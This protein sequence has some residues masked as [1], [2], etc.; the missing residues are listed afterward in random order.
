[1]PV[2]G[3]DAAMD[4][5]LGMPL[6][7]PAAAFLSN[8]A[9]QRLVAG[10]ADPVLLAAVVGQP[11]RLAANPQQANQGPPGQV[12]R[13]VKP[14]D[15]AGALVG[16]FFE[17]AGA[18]PFGA[19]GEVLPP[20]LTVQAV[21]WDNATLDV[22]VSA[23]TRRGSEE[24][25][26]PK[27]LLRPAAPRSGLAPYSADVAAQA[28]TV[29]MGE[30]S[31]A[32]WEAKRPEYFG[33]KSTDAQHRSFEAEAHRRA[34]LLNVR[35][36]TLNTRLIQG[37][38]YNRFDPVIEREV[39]AANEA[40]GLKGES[41]LDPDLV[42]SMMFQESEMGTAGQHLDL[43]S[44]HPMKNRFNILQVI[45]S[46]GTALMTLLEKEHP[47][48]VE[49]YHLGQ[50]RQELN[51]AL[52]ERA[53]LQRRKQ[54][55]PQEAAR[56]AALDV[57]LKQNGEYFIYNYIAPGESAGFF[58]AAMELFN[59]SSPPLN[60][61]YDFWI[62]AAVFWLFEKHRAGMSWPDAVRAYNGSGAKANRYRDAVVGRKTAAE[63]A[64]SAGKSFVPGR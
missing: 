58:A 38:M 37:T 46:S 16:Q 53:A 40:H 45:D 22:L 21:E 61:T 11:V 49:K 35:R 14:D 15:V 44:T 27:R 2:R 24:I 52:E 12:I 31:I 51:E 39:A 36:A 63:S 18:V 30:A 26:V 19:S 9:V 10:D 8:V 43:D 48:L 64:Q 33:P 20:G 47:D 42:K 41:A 1:L 60:E 50:W 28:E 4:L 32:D 7:A 59:R 13:P 25:R 57:R 34:D 23:P 5:G 55:T 29:A 62:H 3:D 54:R 17:L 6:G 56:L